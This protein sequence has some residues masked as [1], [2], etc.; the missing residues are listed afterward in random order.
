MTLA[1]RVVRFLIRISFLTY[2][3]KFYFINKENIPE[4]GP[5]L[6]AANHP[7]AFLEPMIHAPFIKH[8]S[9]FILR[10]D[11]FEK[12]WAR[13]I[14]NNLNIIPIF[15]Q[16]DGIENLRKNAN[17]FGMFQD[18][19]HEKKNITIMVEGSHDYRKHL[20]KVQRGTARMTLGTYKEYGDEDITIL[21]MG[22]TFTDLLSIR[23]TVMIKFGKPILLKDYLELH[24][25]NERKAMLKITADI[26]AELRPCMVHI[27]DLEHYEATDFVLEMN[28]NNE[29]VGLWRPYSQNPALLEREIEIA[30]RI[31][32][33]EQK[34][35]LFRQIASYQTALNEAKISDLGLGKAKQFNFLNT[36]LLLFFFPAFLL[37]SLVHAPMIALVQR[38]KSKMKKAE[39]KVSM[40]FV[41]LTFGYP[42]F[43]LLWI[44]AALIIQNLWFGIFVAVLPLLAFF[45]LIYWD[46]L[47]YWNAA[48]KFNA[49]KKSVRTALL[50]KREEILEM[51]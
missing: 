5:I 51:I 38:L 11:Y 23:S 37:I 49:L 1:Y 15:R 40:G 27:E 32:R 26:Q 22:V 21:P 19:L 34:E 25:Q 7:T 12:D 42:I 35:Q 18:L 28:R 24:A 45:G 14:L 44:I 46:R 17:L 30:N 2:F 36:F 13:R 43:W 29:N 4:K 8:A 39:F 10:G 9:Y 33:Y 48:R 31:N 20:R 3:Q 50:K 6:F 47:R 16:R 41:A